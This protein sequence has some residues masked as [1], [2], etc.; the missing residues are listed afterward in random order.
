M[1]I[2]LNKIF[3]RKYK[4]G[5]WSNIPKLQFPKGIFKHNINILSKQKKESKKFHAFRL[6]AYKKY[7]QIK[8][9]LWSNLNITKIN[10]NKLILYSTPKVKNPN[11]NKKLLSTFKKCGLFLNKNIAIDTVFD[12]VSI[13]I[14]FKNKLAKYGI[15]FCSISKAIQTYPNLI[16]I[17][18]GM[19]VPYSDNFFAALNS[20]IFSDGSFCYI[21]KNTKCPLELSTYFRINDKISGQFERTLIIVESNSYLSYLEGCTATQYST[22]QL[23]AAVVELIV[24]TNAIIKYSTVQNWYSG[25]KNGV[26]GIFNCVTKRGL[27]FGKNASI[28][29]TQVEV[30]SSIT[31][32]Y[33]SSILVGDSAIS[34]FYSIA[35]TNYYQQTDTGTKMIHLGK[36]TKSKIISKSISTG[37]S[38]NTYRGLIKI[39]KTAKYSKIYSQCDSL[40]L[41]N[42]SK[43]R[44]YPYIDILNF[45]SMI[46]HEAKISQINDEQFF[47]L[48]QRG[49]NKI[50]ILNIMLGS[51]CKDIINQLPMEFALEANY[52]LQLELS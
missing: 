33:P 7:K 41:G 5:F 49:M 2:N 4:F 24:F 23:H 22:N 6:K 25:D 14:T 36:Y 26:G 52:L 31:W 8:L 39:G 17:F 10:L 21:P 9:P 13:N 16:N 51:F 19:V 46:E 29:W 1:N 12:S 50:L 30:G 38:K 47:Y 34:E 35:L 28:I 45:T 44:A 15:I 18:L 43:I 48:Q 32:K 27:C 3:L 42:T 20:A 40:I 11:L 37:F